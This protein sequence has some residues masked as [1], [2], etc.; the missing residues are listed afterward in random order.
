M[1]KLY[2]N[3]KILNSY[4]SLDVTLVDARKYLKMGNDIEVRQSVPT[5]TSYIQQV[6]Y[7]D[8]ALLN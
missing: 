2:V 4:L 1:Y 7:A 6:E 3:G 8:N 5:F